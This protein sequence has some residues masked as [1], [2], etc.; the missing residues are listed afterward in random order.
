MLLSDFLCLPL[1]SI[2][3]FKEGCKR[4]R[5]NSMG[6]LGM[7]AL[8]LVGTGVTVLAQ[9]S[10]PAGGQPPAAGGGGRQGGGRQGGFGQFGGGQF[11]GRGGAQLS[12]LSVAT[13]D[14][15]LTLTAD[16]KTKIKAILDKK[17]ADTKALPALPAFTPGQP[18]ADPQAFQE[19]FQKRGEIN[20]KANSDIHALLTDDQK[21]K[22]PA[23]LQELGAMQQAGIPGG[24]LGDLKLTADQKKK[25]LAQAQANQQEM[26]DKM[27]AAQQSGQRMSREDMMAMRK[28]ATDK[29]TALLTPTQRATLEKYTREHP[30][31]AFGGFGG[32][33][34]QNGPGA[35]AGAP[36]GA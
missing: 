30:Q 19:A 6:L 2:I 9:D 26:R 24:V 1:P 8:M 15:G 23:F 29:V 27:Q 22:L 21:A 13:M 7:T 18:P 12:N 35:P 16:Q 11:G 32:G 3:Y 25:V 4:M 36:G 28:D 34:R 5:H 33:R 10:P 14:S 17:D 31:P 20:A